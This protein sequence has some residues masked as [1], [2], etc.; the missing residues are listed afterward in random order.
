M[1]AVERAQKAGH[2][3]RPLLTLI[4]YTK[5]STEKRLWVIDL[6]TKRVLFHEL[7]AHGRG[8]GDNYATKFS[9]ENRTLASS[10]GLFETLDPYQGKHGYSLKLR[11]LDPGVNDKAESRAIVV[12]GAWYVSDTFAKE[13][14]RLGRSWGCP[15]LDE[16]VAKKIIDAI[17]GQSLVFAYYSSM[18]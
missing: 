16:K 18:D 6:R 10:L 13:H 12:H 15:A 9:N 2:G 8:S 1:K 11:G 3:K 14:G 4:D 17:K 5:P 7:V